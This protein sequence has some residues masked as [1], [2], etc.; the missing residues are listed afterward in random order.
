MTNNQKK[1]RWKGFWILFA[2]IALLFALAIGVLM[3]KFSDYLQEMDAKNTARQNARSELAVE[4]YIAGLSGDYIAAQLTDLYAQAD[5][6]LQSEEDFRALIS[7]QISGGIDYKVMFTSAEKRT[8]ALY[9]QNAEADG[10]YRQIGELTIEPNGE[11]SYGYTPWG[12]TWAH[13]DMGYLLTPARQI[14]VPEN[15]SV[16]VG[17]KQLDQAYVVRSDINYPSLAP[18]QSLNPVPDLPTLTAYRVGPC[19]GNIPVEIRDPEG[20][21]VT[22]PEDTDW[23]AF[24]PVCPEDTRQRLE[25]FIDEYVALYTVFGSSKKNRHDNY[26]KIQAFIVPDGALAERFYN[27]HGGVQ[28]TDANPDEL[29]SLS[30]NRI[31]PLEDGRY[32]CDITYVVNTVGK[33]EAQEETINC[34]IVVLPVDGELK[35]ESM[36]N[37]T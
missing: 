23:N 33:V 8:Y 9:L 11:A 21:P 25:A 26:E 14:T 36:V 4:N 31:V 27:M 20:T 37:Y 28:W 3:H 1:S 29:I 10:R 19:L 15:Y 12:V 2:V 17:G 34:L 7:S 24:L 5:G 16:W 22:I 30:Y 32:I 6:A 35:V 18:L 13:F